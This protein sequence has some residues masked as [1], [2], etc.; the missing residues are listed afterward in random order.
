MIMCSSGLLFMPS[1][2]LNVRTFDLGLLK[3]LGP[4]ALPNGDTKYLDKFRPGG[5]W[6]ICCFRGD[7][8]PKKPRNAAPLMTR[9]FL[10]D[11]PK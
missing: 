1:T 4:A 10:K 8:F 3:L 7:N 9:I 2:H 6:R 5:R 11:R